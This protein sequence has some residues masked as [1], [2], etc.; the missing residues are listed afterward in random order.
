MQ[1]SIAIKRTPEPLLR[2]SVRLIFLEDL[3]IFGG[4]SLRNPARGAVF[5]RAV[6][7]A[8]PHFEASRAFRPVEAY[9][10]GYAFAGLQHQRFGQADVYFVCVGQAQH[11]RL[12]CQ[13]PVTIAGGEAP[14]HR[15]ALSLG[16]WLDGLFQFICGLLDG[17]GGGGVEQ[18]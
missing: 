12:L 2:R 7:A 5:L 14:A 3:V 16:L 18:Y 10:G 1:N 6:V 13:R 8:R 9:D 11:F 15:I 17:C 4:C